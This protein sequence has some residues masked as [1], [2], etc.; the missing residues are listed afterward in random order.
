SLKRLEVAPRRHG[1]PAPQPQPVIV[2]PDQVRVAQLVAESRH[3]PPL[4]RG[5]C[6]G[7]A[8]AGIWAD[9]A[10]NIKDVFTPIRRGA[11]ARPLPRPRRPPCRPR[12]GSPRRR[13]PPGTRCGRPCTAFTPAPISGLGSVSRLLQ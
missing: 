11:P 8:F 3:W 1:R 9:Y 2:E 5:R 4:R 7:V 6:D 10:G 12:R 13:S